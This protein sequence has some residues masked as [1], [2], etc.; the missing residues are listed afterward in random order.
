MDRTLNGL[1]LLLGLPYF[2]HVFTASHTGIINYM[3]SA[4]IH[5]FVYCL[6]WLSAGW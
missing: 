1:V 4:G 2:L 6:R 5:Q 3:P